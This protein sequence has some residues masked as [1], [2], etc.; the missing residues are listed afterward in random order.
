[1][2]RDRAVRSRP[3][4]VGVRRDVSSET[5]RRTTPVNGHDLLA[6]G[7]V[8]G[9]TFRRERPSVVLYLCNYFAVTSTS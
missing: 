7:G 6:A 4:R 3:V 1:M 5:R 8:R 9:Q 2:R